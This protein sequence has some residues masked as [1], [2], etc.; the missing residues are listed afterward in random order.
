MHF[1]GNATGAGEVRDLDGALAIYAG[2]DYG[3]FNISMLDATPFGEQDPSFQNRLTTCASYFAKR[4]SRWSFWLCEDALEAR[5]RRRASDVLEKYGLHRIADAPGMMTTELAEPMRA[6]PMMDCV[7]VSDQASRESFAGIVAV[8]FDI[9]MSIVRAVYYPE[10][11]WHGA[12]QGF[13]GSVGGRPVAV[14]AIV[15]TG[16]ALGVYSLATMPDERERGYGEA[17][18]R[19]AVAREQARTG[20]HKLVLQSTEAGHS[21]YKRLGFRQVARFSVYL[22]S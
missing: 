14:V 2:L 4:T 17:L 6:L 21:L 10:R 13:V 18:L 20:I 5:D 19:A 8:S 3:V 16:D 15:A 11:A 1:F 7:P 12:Y 22:T 9:P